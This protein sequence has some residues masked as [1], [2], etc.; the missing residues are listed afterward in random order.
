MVL[1]W[2]RVDWTVS[3]KA[4][5]E[6]LRLDKCGWQWAWTLLKLRSISPGAGP[7]GSAR[8]SG[9]CLYLE[10]WG[11]A[12]SSLLAFTFYLF[13]LLGWSYQAGPTSPWTA[14]G[15]RLAWPAADIVEV[16]P[17][18]PP[19]YLW[20]GGKKTSLRLNDLFMH[21]SMDN[22]FPMVS[23]ASKVS[24]RNVNFME[25][26]VSSS[27]GRWVV[28]K[29]CSPRGRVPRPHPAPD[30]WPA[31]DWMLINFTRSFPLVSEGNFWPG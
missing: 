30:H 4:T 24:F 6:P 27:R 17:L 21:H 15:P 14:L 11:S 12:W 8:L 3:S 31:L 2:V 26:W 10:L 23:S 7:V 20:G 1:A 22:E 5:E 18:P 13:Y 9:H 25:T 19:H 29:T 28:Q 16:F